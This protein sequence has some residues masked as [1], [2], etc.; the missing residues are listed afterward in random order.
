[1]GRKAHLVALSLIAAALHVMAP[2]PAFSAQGP[3]LTGTFGLVVEQSDDIPRA[4]EGAVA[5]MNFVMRPL[6]RSRL[7]VINTRYERLMIDASNDAVTIVADSRA[8]IC[9]PAN[10]TAV[11]WRREDGE[12]FNVSGE[13]E[14]TAFEQTFVS[15]TGR[16]INRYSLGPDGST[17]E[18]QVEISGGG[19]TGPMTY[20]LVYRRLS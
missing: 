9:T 20:H 6:A 11:A 4:I 18:L 15:G 16:R 3:N 13:W 8:P 19:L 5:K 14:G 10:G 1:M 12:L 2:A 7:R 17:L